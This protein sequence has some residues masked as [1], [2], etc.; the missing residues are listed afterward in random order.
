MSDPTPNA[1]PFCGTEPRLELD[2]NV[3]VACP[4]F[5][6]GAT[7]PAEES[8]D[9]AVRQWNRIVLLEVD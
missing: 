1:C 7:G 6:C 8:D 4:N 2:D 5:D 3:F 9:E